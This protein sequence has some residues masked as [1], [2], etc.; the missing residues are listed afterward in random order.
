V[1]VMSA[2]GHGLEGPETGGGS[3]QML[4]VYVEDVDGH[5]R[6]TRDHGATILSELQDGFWGGRIYRAADPEGHRWEFSAAGRDLAA[7]AWALPPGLTRG[8]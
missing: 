2:G 6:R 7:A 4:K 1:N 3:S 5:F 8:S